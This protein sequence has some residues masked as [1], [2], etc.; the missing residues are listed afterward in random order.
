MFMMLGLAV[1]LPKVESGFEEFGFI[2]ERG[3]L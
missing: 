3:A 2:Q 1:N